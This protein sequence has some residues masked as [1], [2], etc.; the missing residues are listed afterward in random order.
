M[1]HRLRINHK[2]LWV[3]GKVIGNAT[4]QESPQE[5]VRM[6]HR[7]LRELRECAEALVYLLRI[8]WTK[9]DLDLLEKLWWDTKPY[10]DQKWAS[11]NQP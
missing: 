1:S 4:R 8:G 9:K 10:R 6:D 3:L 11:G 2:E 7:R 5:I